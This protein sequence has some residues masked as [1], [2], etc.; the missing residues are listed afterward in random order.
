MDENN[1]YVAKRSELGVSRAVVAVALG[2]GPGTVA[3][4]EK[5]GG[6]SPLY[7]TV[8][9]AYIDGRYDVRIRAMVRTAGSDLNA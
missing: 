3:R 2:V 8:R 1:P 4:W 7:H 9:L 6:A 5:G